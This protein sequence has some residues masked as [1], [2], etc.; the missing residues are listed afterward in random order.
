MKR[1]IISKKEVQRKNIDTL[2]NNDYIFDIRK[3]TNI[4]NQIYLNDEF[5]DKNLIIKGL[6]KKLRSYKSQDEKQ[7]RYNKDDFI[8][9]NDLVEK[10]VLS[11]LKCK[12]C[13]IDLFLMYKT[14][15][16]PNQWTLDRIDNN[17][18]HTSINTVICCLKCNIQRG[19]L[20]DK[21]FLFTK[22]MRI[23]KKI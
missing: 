11:K 23:V 7:N 15:R 1:I 6:K 8:T 3:Q 2:I 16:E 22:Q 5:D 18:Q 9:Y 19:R 4:I 14:V 21:K 10:I 20:N 17:I 12:Y 13:F